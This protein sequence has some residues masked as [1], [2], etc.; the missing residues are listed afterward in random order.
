MQL[1]EDPLNLGNYSIFYVL[2]FGYKTLINVSI[3]KFKLNMI[4]KKAL[5]KA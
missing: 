2:N 4:K 5:N 1:I 3:N